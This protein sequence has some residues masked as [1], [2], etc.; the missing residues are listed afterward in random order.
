MRESKSEERLI[1]AVGLFG[2]PRALDLIR[3]SVNAGDAATRASA[4]EAL[5]TLGDRKITQQILPILDHGGVFQ[6]SED[7]TLNIEDALGIL[8]TD[9]DHWLRALAAQAVPELGLSNYVGVLQ[10]LKKDKHPL[11]KQAASDALQQLDGT[12]MKTLKTLSTLERILLLR[13]VP[14]FAGL[15]PEDLEKIADIAHEQIYA[16][17]GIICREGEPGDA[18]FIIVSGEVEVVKS[19]GRQESI[20]ATRGPGEFVGEMAILDSA[21][22]S[23][24][25]RALND[26]RVLSIEG[27]AFKSILLDRPEVAVSA[28]RNM[29]AR[30]RALN[31]RIGSG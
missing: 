12:K 17:G 11:V 30:I 22:R 18:L 10:K 25:L 24:T 1:K 13:E 27:D 5:E 20:L 19:M 29:S 3:K 6:K 2:N 26:V 23:A 4:L 21:P 14:M 8:L 28:L 15:A 31:E 9:E 7:E 16:T